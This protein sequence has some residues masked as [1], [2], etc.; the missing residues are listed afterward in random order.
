MDQTQKVSLAAALN[1]FIRTPVGSG[2]G[3]TTSEGLR[4]GLR[5]LQRQHE[6]DERWQ[7]ASPT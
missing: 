6:P 5:L 2:Q 7:D 4:A 3:R 1:A